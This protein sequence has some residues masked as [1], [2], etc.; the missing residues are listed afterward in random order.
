MPVHSAEARAALDTIFLTKLKGTGLYGGARRP[1]ESILQGVRDAV[2]FVRYWTAES[3]PQPLTL[4]DDR[5]AQ[6]DE[7]WVP[8]RTA[9]GPGFLLWPN[10]D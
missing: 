2:A 1:D 9:D 7:G 8:V 4:D 6:V 5:A 3:G 10:S